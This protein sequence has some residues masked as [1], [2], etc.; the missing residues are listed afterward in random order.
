[1]TIIEKIEVAQDP[2][3]KDRK[4]SQ[5]RIFFAP[6][7]KG[8]KM[9][10]STKIKRDQHF[11]SQMKKRRERGAAF[12]RDP[13]SYKKAP[14]DARAKTKPSPETR[15]VRRMMGEPTESLKE[16]SFEEKAKKSGIP[17]GILKQ[18]YRRGVAAHASGG[19]RPG[20]TP[21]QWGH[22]R[23]NSFI[24]GGRTR[25]KGDPDLWA[26]AKAAKARKKK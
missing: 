23:V 19:H 10:K 13:S 8:R 21:Q 16:A 2:D 15:K 12:D 9:S 26:K 6:D 11:K 17:V 18:V 1:M 4:G 22:A 14:G 24:S 3:I 20:T 7:A 5:D 25:V